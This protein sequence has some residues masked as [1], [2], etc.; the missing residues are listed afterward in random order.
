MDQDFFGSHVHDLGRGV[1]GEPGKLEAHVWGAHVAGT[2]GVEEVEEI[3]GSE[4][5]RVHGDSDKAL[6]FHAAAYLSSLSV[7]KDRVGLVA[8]CAS[9]IRGVG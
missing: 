2:G 9:M 6:L 1:H 5:F 4:G 8:N 3:V 7:F